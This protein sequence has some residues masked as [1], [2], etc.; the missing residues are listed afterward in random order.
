MPAV[1]R[2]RAGFAFVLLLLGAGGLLA[3]AV[4]LQLLN[5]NS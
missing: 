5:R 4:D 2:L 1:F 3:R